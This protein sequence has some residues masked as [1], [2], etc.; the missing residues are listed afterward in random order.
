MKKILLAFCAVTLLLISSC[1]SVGNKKKTYRGVNYRLKGDWVITDISY[2]K[3]YV[4]KPFDEMIDIACFKGSS[5]K[6]ITNNNSGSY[7]ISD[8]KCVRFT[9]DI[10]FNVTEDGIFS[11]KKIPS[12]AKAKS[13][14]SGYFLQIQNYSPESFGLLFPKS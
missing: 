5:W 1:S 10:K 6:L 13:V 14:K 7:T 3:D 9:T 4:I 2:N 11:F 8:P 12:G